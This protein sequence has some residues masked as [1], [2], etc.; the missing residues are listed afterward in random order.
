MKQNPFRLLTK[1][2]WGLWI[3]SLIVVTLSFLLV[4]TKDWLTLIASLIGVTALIFTAK[5]HYIGMFLCV[6]FAVFYGIISFYFEYYGEMITYMCMSAPISFVSM[7]NWIKNPYH[8]KEEVRV[9]HL[10]PKKIVF[11]VLMTIAVTTLF[12]FILK[13]LG[14]ANLL[15]ST[16]SIAT[17]CVACCL[18]YLRSPYY[19]LGYSANDIVLI[20]LWVMASVQDPGYLPM[21]FCFVMFLANDLYGFFN[22]R[23]MQR[24]QNQ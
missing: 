16:L 13:A 1:F 5:G 11:V 19:A 21:I 14:N 12:Y 20:V 9:S 18:T 7:I 3:V 15:T 17:S 6:V 22:W 4:P 8:G 2:E 23:R 24:R 10:T